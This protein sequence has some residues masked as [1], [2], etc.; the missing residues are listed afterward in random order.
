MRKPGEKKLKYRERAAIRRE[1][2]G[3][4]NARMNDEMI[5]RDGHLHCEECGVNESGVLSRHHVKFKSHGGKDEAGNLR[6]LCDACHRAKHHRQTP[7]ERR[8]FGS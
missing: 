8:S 4:L 6:L 1:T 2:W 7:R 3:E 5:A